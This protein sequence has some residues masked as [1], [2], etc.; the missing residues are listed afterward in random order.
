MNLRISLLTA[1]FTSTGLVLNPTSASAFTLGI[2]GSFTLSGFS[3]PTLSNTYT[4]DDSVKEDFLNSVSDNDSSIPLAPLLPSF[5]DLLSQFPVPLPFPTPVTLEN[6]V[7]FSGTGA[8]AITNQGVVDFG[9]VFVEEDPTLQVPVAEV[10]FD[11]NVA[12]CV[13][14]SCIWSG[15]FSELKLSFEEGQVANVVPPGNLTFTITSTP[16]PTPTPQAATVTSNLQEATP[17]PETTSVLGLLAL[18]TLGAIIGGKRQEARG[19]RQ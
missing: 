13:E 11:E 5:N 17:V 4:F 18:G 14:V 12:D 16:T 19:K 10:T 3:G 1:T 9:F 15:S 2:Q 6:L 7:D 8:V